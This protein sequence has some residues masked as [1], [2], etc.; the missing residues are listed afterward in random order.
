M[1]ELILFKN[2][3]ADEMINFNALLIKNYRKLDVNE[4]D[5][6]V[7]SCLERQESKGQKV[8]N[9]SS[10]KAKVGLSDDDLNQCLDYLTKK[11]YL[12]IKQETN[13][14]TNKQTE[15]FSID[16]IYKKLI[17]LY[18]QD[19][20]APISQSF[21][22]SVVDAFNDIFQ[23]QISPAD[24]EVIKNWAIG[25]EF[26]YDE[27]NAEMLDAAKIGKSSLTYVDQ[28]LFKKHLQKRES[29]EYIE[30]NDIV[31]ELRNKWKK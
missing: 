16:N 18:T 31:E 26:T 11:N 17:D 27:I 19:S 28:V 2:L 3:I 24:L 7:L 22:E 8:F 13:P 15:M 14:K 23:T 4:K 25:K 30:A 20:L 5:I 10:V 21:M 6:I 29:P 12:E 9:F 1:K